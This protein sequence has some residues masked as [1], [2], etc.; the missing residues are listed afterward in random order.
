MNKIELSNERLHEKLSTR[1]SFVVT[2]FAQ[3]IHFHGM[4]I[5]TTL[6]TFV[7]SKYTVL[8]TWEHSKWQLTS[9]ECQECLI[10]LIDLTYVS[11]QLHCICV[12]WQWHFW[13]ILNPFHRMFVQLRARPTAK[14]VYCSFLRLGHCR[15][16]EA[17]IMNKWRKNY[18]QAFRFPWFS[19]RCP[20]GQKSCEHLGCLFFLATDSTWAFDILL[21]RIILRFLCSWPGHGSRKNLNP[22]GGG[23]KVVKKECLIQRWQNETRVLSWNKGY[24]SIGCTG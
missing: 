2:G 17:L 22:V 15:S 20:K 5:H 12:S 14:P 3:L 19:M 10:C 8:V 6:I 9:A 21:M 4:S 24:K 18:N 1:A 16:F 7:Q 13:C 11:R 23:I